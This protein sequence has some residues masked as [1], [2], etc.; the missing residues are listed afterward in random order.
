MMKASLH[1]VLAVAFVWVTAPAPGAQ[2]PDFSG[3]WMFDASAST[4]MPKLPSIGGSIGS[5]VGAG[6]EGR[7]APAGTFDPATGRRSPGTIDPNRLAIKQSPTELHVTNGGVELLYRLDGT[8][9]NIS[10]IGRAGF[11]RGKAVWESGK[12]VIT[13]RQSVYRGR[14]EY[15]DLT[16]REVY[17]LEGDVLTIERTETNLEGK[18]ETAKLVYRRA[19]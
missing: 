16:G 8:E 19:S 18:A 9:E 17:S 7:A 1:C 12:V 13:T 15:A 4:G 11:P 10:A 5:V 14:G 6:G 2:A 3:T